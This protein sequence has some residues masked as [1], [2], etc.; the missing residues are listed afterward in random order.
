M[1][2]YQY[3]ISK[4]T[5]TNHIP[6]LLPSGLIHFASYQLKVNDP[7]KKAKI[8]L[9]NDW[10]NNKQNCIPPLGMVYSRLKVSLALLAADMK[11]SLF[12]VLS[13]Q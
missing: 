13:G 8:F 12:A 11:Y 1:V 7:E 9:M 6:P 2:A 10:Y 3:H 5:N 4:N